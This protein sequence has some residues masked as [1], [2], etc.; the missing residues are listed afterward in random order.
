MRGGRPLS[1]LAVAALLSPVLAGCVETQQSRWA[2]SMIEADALHD[3]GLTGAGVVVAV[4]D[5]GL[6]AKHAV[7]D[8]VR[9]VRWRDLVNHLPDP[10][11]DAGHGTHVTSIVAG[12]A[13]GTRSLSGVA[14]DGVAPGATILPVKAI[15]GGGSGRDGDVADAVDHAASSGA[16]IIVLSLGGGTLPILGTETEGAVNRA[17]DRGIFVVAAAGNLAEGRDRCSVASPASVPRV[18]AVSAVDEGRRLANFACDGQNSGAI[19][20]IGA[21]ADPHKKPELL[22]PG[23]GIVGAWRDGGYATVDG[24]SQAAPYVAGVLAL[25]LEAK[26][27]LARRDAATVERVKTVLARTAEKI[28]PLGGS[29]GMSHDDRYGY[30]ILRGARALDALGR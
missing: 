26:P 17:I 6:E 12:H 28:G 1:L 22:A 7:F 9:V 2:L 10:Y 27:D 11:D 13:G 24:T 23:V 18:I 4:V 14:V 20:G 21:A 3:R 30:G 19:A 29:S 16:H 25:I 5:T 8:G 15:P